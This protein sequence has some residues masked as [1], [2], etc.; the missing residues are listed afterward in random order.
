MMAH[1]GWAENRA[2]QEE[3]LQVLESIF[4]TRCSV[5]ADEHLCEVQVVPADSELESAF[6]VATCF[7]LRVHLP[8]TY[9]ST[10]APVAEIDAPW[11]TADARVRIWEGLQRLASESAGQ[12]VVFDWVNWLKE[13]E[14]MWQQALS[15]LDLQPS[16]SSPR[17]DTGQP[18]PTPPSS[19]QGEASEGHTASSQTSQSRRRGG[20]GGGGVGGGDGAEGADETEAMTMMDVR[21]LDEA[22]GIKHGDAVTERKSTFQAHVAPVRSVEEVQA[23]LDALLRNRKVA[24]ATH[25]SMAFRIVPPDSSNVLQDSD[26]DG[27]SAAGGRLLHLLQIVDARNVVV[28]VSRW[29]GGTLLGPDRF[30]FISNSARSLLDTCGYIPEPNRAKGNDN[31]YANQSRSILFGKRRLLPPPLSESPGVTVPTFAGALHVLHRPGICDADS[32]SAAL[33]GVIDGGGEADGQPLEDGV[34]A[35]RAEQQHHVRRRQLGH[36]LRRLLQRAAQR[37]HRPAPTH[38]R[39][40]PQH[41]QHTRVSRHTRAALEYMQP[42]TPSGLEIST[43]PQTNRGGMMEAA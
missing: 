5:F 13:Q 7:H 3:E 39:A 11:L 6:D 28:V 8:E 37:L 24:A 9:P 12:V 4:G 25:N 14:W 32:I 29:F 27:E 15:W 2:A 33:E 23:V 22:L 36:L 17:P 30:K 31:V 18:G 19:R 43:W 40:H 26:D 41:S 21:E 42:S 10:S 20:G 38:A 1:E 35:Q 34:E 16:V